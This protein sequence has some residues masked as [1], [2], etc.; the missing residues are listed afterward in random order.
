MVLLFSFA[1]LRPRQPCHG[2]MDFDGRS[3]RV[4]PDCAR[5][6][7]TVGKVATCEASGQWF[8]AE[9]ASGSLAFFSCSLRSS[10]NGSRPR[11]GAGG[12]KPTGDQVGSHVARD[13][14]LRWTRGCNIEI[15]FAEGQS[16]FTEQTDSGSNFG[17]RGIHFSCPE[18]FVSSGRGTRSSTGWRALLQNS[19]RFAAESGGRRCVWKLRTSTFTLV[20]FLE[21]RISQSFGVRRWQDHLQVVF[22]ACRGMRKVGSSW[23]HRVHG[24][25]CKIRFDGCFDHRWGREAP[26][27]SW[28][29]STSFHGWT[30]GEL[31][32]S[33]AVS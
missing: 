25:Q 6:T 23:H 11:C 22:S 19:R 21:L 7:T 29:R 9:W 26:L 16:C 30:P 15:F 20:E 10:H 32:E 14:R 4:G 12:C 2:G 27:S 28:E 13:G 3:L 17:D 8:S 31:R 33:C 24:H 18:T 1:F 5:A